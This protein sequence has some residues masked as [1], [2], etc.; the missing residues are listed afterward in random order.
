MGE[1]HLRRLFLEHLGASP[2]AVAQTRRVQLAK[3]LLDETPIS[4]VQVA[5]AAGFGSVRR[6]N[7]AMKKVY[8]RSPL[9]LRR[10]NGNGRRAA[11][12]SLNLRL[13]YRPPYDWKA[14]A[15]FFALRAIPGV[16]EV[17]DGV[18]RRTI[19]VGESAG[20]IAVRQLPGEP[21]LVLEV[22]IELAGHLAQIAERV[23][24]MFDC[25]AE[26][27]KIAGLFRRD[28]VLRKSA[29][30][31]PGLRLPGAWDGF[32]LVIRA[33][34]G[35][36]VTVAGAT[37]LSGRLVERYGKRL[38]EKEQD[39]PAWIFPTPEALAQVDPSKLSMPQA[40]GRTIVAI[41]QEV[42]DGNLILDGSADPDDVI[43]RLLAI[44]GI[45]DWTAQ[46][47]AMRALNDSDA[48]PASDLGVRRALRIG[49][50]LPGVRAVKSRA[51]AW[52]PWRGYAA[53][54]LWMEG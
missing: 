40:R 13:S 43:E 54:H 45:G 7:T 16:E 20:V 4:M 41:A 44:P 3:R 8:D 51:E 42:C 5:D 2:I 9:Q 50:K 26:P 49:R 36:Q 6:F 53:M 24:W 39:G 38:G 47:V 37:T 32:E 1:R 23:R 33:I 52:R 35:Q 48:F 15:G 17:R 46:Y 18:Y 12:G 25:N 14:I 19:V 29:R 11:V 34:L 21:A 27:R 28:P 31:R 10:N 22:P 30:A